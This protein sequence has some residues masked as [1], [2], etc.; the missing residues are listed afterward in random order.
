M[1]ANQRLLSAAK[2]RSLQGMQAAVR[3]GA[4]IN[5]KSETG[6]TAL[7]L[8][9][10]SQSPDILAFVL[11]QDGIDVNQPAGINELPPLLVADD[12]ANTHAYER[13][14]RDKR[15]NLNA[16]CPVSGDT[17]L[18]RAAKR[19]DG[20]LVRR[21]LALGALA[22]AATTS[23]AA[24]VREGGLSMRDIIMCVS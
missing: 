3:E 19:G 11:G 16:R 14:A 1:N 13:L 4:N 5:H 12:Y 21:L 15:T 6:L 20:A 18:V 22:D 9:I 8:A 2:G 17:A 10:I 7:Q 24:A 23:L